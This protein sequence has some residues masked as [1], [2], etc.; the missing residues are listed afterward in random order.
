[1]FSA[2]A[3]IGSTV[4]GSP[5]SSICQRGRVLLLDHTIAVLASRRPAMH[6]GLAGVHAFLE[7]QLHSSDDACLKAELEQ[8]NKSLL[9]E[10]ILPSR[11]REEN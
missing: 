6:I 4:D 5:I 7:R 3:D 9:L 8:P 11:V 2:R 10:S 1:M